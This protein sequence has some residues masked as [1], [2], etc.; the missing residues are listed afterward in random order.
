MKELMSWLFNGVESNINVTITNNTVHN[1]L[2]FHNKLDFY[3]FVHPFPYL[4]NY[5]SV[6]MT[7]TKSGLV[8]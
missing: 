1:Y 3:I 5:S 7:K 2:V 6:D 8:S 4:C